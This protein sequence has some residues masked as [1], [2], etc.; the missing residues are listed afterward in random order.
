VRKLAGVAALRR[1][2]GHMGLFDTDP[3]FDREPIRDPVLAEHLQITFDLYQTAEN[4]M[5]LNLRR[6]HPQADEAEIDRRLLTWLRK[7]DGWR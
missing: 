7:Q 3:L 2:M 6:N 5:R 4:I 1:R